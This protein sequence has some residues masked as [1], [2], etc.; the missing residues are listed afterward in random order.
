MK[1]KTTEI[2]MISI[3]MI[4]GVDWLIKIPEDP[5]GPINIK[6]NTTKMR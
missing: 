3:T 6:I 5:M 2:K 4:L 1:Q